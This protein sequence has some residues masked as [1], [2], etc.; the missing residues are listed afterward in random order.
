MPR[1]KR[2]DGRRFS[3][4]ADKTGDIDGEKIARRDI[5]VHGFE[6][7]VIGVDVMWVLPMERVNCPIR[8]RAHG[9]GIGTDDGVLPVGLVPYRNN[10][11]SR[12]GSQDAGLEL[13]FG[14]MR[15]AVADSYGIFLRVAS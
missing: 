15:E 1:E 12:A 10:L 5:A 2:A 6:R 9:A 11:Y 7:N 3:R 13:R 4:L 8:G 14:L